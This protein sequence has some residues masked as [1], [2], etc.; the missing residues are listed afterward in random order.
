MRNQR[1]CQEAKSDA[2]SKAGPEITLTLR[3]TALHTS[4]RIPPGVILQIKMPSLAT[5]DR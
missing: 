3:G 1:A 4:S 2:V 5:T